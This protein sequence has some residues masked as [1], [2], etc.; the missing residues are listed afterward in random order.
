MF[1]LTDIQATLYIYKN[2]VELYN[3]TVR[4]LKKK[5]EI[6]HGESTGMI[7]IFKTKFRYFYTP[8]EDKFCVVV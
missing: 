1:Y 7:G 2:Q 6:V 4:F 3:Y 8:F 5:I